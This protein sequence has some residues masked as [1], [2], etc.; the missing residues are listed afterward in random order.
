VTTLRIF[1]RLATSLDTDENILIL[2]Q[3]CPILEINILIST[4]SS[5]V[6]HNLVY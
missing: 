5:E 2:Y 1:E 6:S 4:P 3:Y